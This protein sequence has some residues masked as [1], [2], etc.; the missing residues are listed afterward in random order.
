M[1]LEN[2]AEETLHYVLYFERMNGGDKVVYFEPYSESKLEEEGVAFHIVGDEIETTWEREEWYIRC[3]Y[4][5][6]Q[7]ESIEVAN[8]LCKE[9]NEAVVKHQTAK[10]MEEGQKKQQEKK[11]NGGHKKDKHLSNGSSEGIDGNGNVV[12]GSPAKVSRLILDGASGSDDGLAMGPGAPPTEVRTDEEQAVYEK[13]MEILRKHPYLES[14]REQLESG[15]DDS[16][17]QRSEKLERL[18]EVLEGRRDLK[19]WFIVWIKRDL[20]QTPSNTGHGTGD[21]KEPSQRKEEDQ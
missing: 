14:I 13:R 15:D 9:H 19:C 2:N 12:D 21:K 7:K 11:K 17:Q 10:Q 8:R 6:S 20:K 16:I 4:I 3:L 18:K 1:N 5:G